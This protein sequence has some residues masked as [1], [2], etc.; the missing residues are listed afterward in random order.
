MIPEIEDIG[1][2]F[3]KSIKYY[4]LIN[5]LYIFIYLFFIMLDAEIKTYINKKSNI[6]NSHKKE[7]CKF[8]LFFMYELI[9]SYFIFLMLYKIF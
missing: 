9:V 6:I 3:K 8:S 7:I 5:K 4:F 1:P 2:V